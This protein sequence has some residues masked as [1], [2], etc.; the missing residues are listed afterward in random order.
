MARATKAA[1]VCTECPAPV[2]TFQ[3]AVEA[4]PYD[5]KVIPSSPLHVKFNQLTAQYQPSP[6]QRPVPSTAP[7]PGVK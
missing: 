2:H 6:Y 7:A 3:V 5:I 1:K 4:Y